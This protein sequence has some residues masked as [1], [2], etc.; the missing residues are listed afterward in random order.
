MSDRLSLRPRIGAP[1]VALIALVAASSGAQQPAPPPLGPQPV[2]TPDHADG[3]YR[4][5]ERVGW[6]VTLPR[7]VAKSAPVAGPYSYTVRRNGGDVVS[8]G[9]LVFHNGRARL[10]TTLAEPAMLLVDVRPPRADSTFGNRSNGGPGRIRLG[11]AV[12]PDEIQPAEPKPADFDAFWAAKLKTLAAVPIAPNETAGE[13]GVTGV[14]WSTVKLD[15]VNGAHVYAQVAKPAR[16][17]KLPALVIYHWASPPY[18]LQK[19][20]ATGPA[21]QGWL[22]LDVEP[23]DVPPDMPQS[24]YDALPTMIKQY[25]TIGQR[26]R[27]DSYFL[28]MY[29]G[30]VRAIDY[31]ATRPDWDGHTVVVLGTSMGGQ[32][33]FA[34][35]GLDPRVTALLVNVPAGADV[36]AALHGRGPSYPNWDVTRPEVLATA[37]YFDPANFASRITARSLVAMGFIDDVAAPAGIW[38]VFNQIRG[39]KEAVPMVESPHNNL[40]TPESERGW[41]ARSGAWLGVLRG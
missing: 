3:V 12:A 30:D 35:A 41:T 22:V 16:E 15:N 32:Q 14:Q 25:N 40:A 38:S 28:Q 8:S 5:G 37:R 6:T 1:L 33:S 31:L 17:G 11:A 29:L 4:R 7:G 27:D 24:F 39:P 26:S 13:S 10:E 2:F 34:V 9:T 18:P 20:W 23:H 36:T 21:A 19:A